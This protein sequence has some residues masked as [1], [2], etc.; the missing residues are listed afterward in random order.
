MYVSM[1]VTLKAY[2]YDV[3]GEVTRME[4]KGI[5]Q[6]TI[7]QIRQEYVDHAITV[8]ARNKFVSASEHELNWGDYSY[9]IIEPAATGL[10][11][12]RQEY[13]YDVTVTSGYRNP[14]HNEGIGVWGSQHQ[15][16]TAVDAAVHDH[17]APTGL[18]ND[19]D[20]M[21]EAAVAASAD[22]TQDYPGD[23]YSHVHADWRN[24]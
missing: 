6:D 11:A 13:A 17:T 19:S 7:D 24:D 14:E 5:E 20:E 16:G 2:D 8:P 3:G 21:L 23:N 12:W 10:S 18:H 4:Q 9:A 22:F 1:A 15:Y